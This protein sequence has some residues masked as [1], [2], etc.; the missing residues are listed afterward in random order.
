MSLIAIDHAVSHR[1]WLEHEFA[2]IAP[3]ELE[4]IPLGLNLHATAPSVLRGSV[5]LFP[6]LLCF[7][8]VSQKDRA[9]LQ[10]QDDR[11]IQ[12]GHPPFFAAFLRCKLQVD[13]LAA[14]LGRMQ[15]LRNGAGEKAWLRVHDSRVWLQLLRVMPPQLLAGRLGPISSW[16]VY[17][18][19]QWQTQSRPNVE[20]RTGP[21]DRRT[22]RAID[23]IGAVNRVIAR[24]GRPARNLQQ[25]HDLSL[26]IDD[27]VVRA[28][29]HYRLTEL[30][31]I[32]EFSARGMAVDLNYDRHPDVAKLM[33]PTP[34]DDN[35]APSEQRTLAD[36]FALQEESFWHRVRM[37]L[38][39]N[40]GTV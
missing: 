36:R 19:G 3:Q 26:Q 1:L 20:A 16:T 13:Q 32:V 28:Q 8:E 34:Q 33:Q 35:V 39:I 31:D 38:S 5:H 25:L 21:V 24:L 10:S 6:R 11:D 18:Q 9:A 2:L 4:R 27:L 14:H 40:Q 37:E 7:S 22:W 29:E 17:W 23:R 30:D 12:S 15:M